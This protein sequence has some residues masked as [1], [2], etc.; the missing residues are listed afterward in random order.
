MAA[1]YKII[2]FHNA[3]IVS[4]ENHGELGN[5]IPGEH[6]RTVLCSPVVAITIPS[7]PSHVFLAGATHPVPLRVPLSDLSGHIVPLRFEHHSEQSQLA[8]LHPVL[9]QYLSAIIPEEPSGYARIEGNRRSVA[10]WE[11]FRLEPLAANEITQRLELLAE[12]LDHLFARGITVNTLLETIRAEAIFGT[13]ELLDAA[14][15]FLSTLNLEKIATLLQQDKALCETLARQMPEDPWA[16]EGIPLLMHWISKRDRH[17]KI[18]PASRYECP[19]NQTVLGVTG[20]HKDIASFA[21]ACVHAMRRKVTPTRG[22]AILACVRNEGIYLLEWIA[23]H[24]A[25]GIEWFFLY[26]NDNDDQSDD[27]LRTLSEQGIITWVNNPIKPGKAAQ[28]KAYGH[29]LSIV[30]D[31]LDFSWVQVLDGDEFLALDPERFSNLQ[32]YLLW[33]ETHPVDAISLNWRFV[34]SEPLPEGEETLF[35]DPLTMRNSRFVRHDVIGDPGSRLVKSMF[36]PAQV[37][38]SQAHYPV[39][40]YRYS[41]TMCL[42]DGTPHTWQSP[43]AGVPSSAAF[44]DHIIFEKIGI[45]HYFYK[46]PEEWMWKSSRNRGDNPSKQGLDLRNFV[47]GWTG[48][49]MSQISDDMRSGED[50]WMAPRRAPFL[51]ELENLKNLPG[52]MQVL[53]NIYTSYRE[54]SA[55][56][57]NRLQAENIRARH[58]ENNK[59][60]FDLINVP[61]QPNS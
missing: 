35:R 29:A 34:A 23:Y 47:D 58:S 21:H 22:P 25:I 54:R 4:E 41:T 27:I 30:P 11:L 49:F 14:L 8:F 40:S 32:D 51:S 9:D 17:G 38:Q 56:I 39:A 6:E 18:A 16:A 61:E 2:T 59:I 28:H 57:R 36:R 31:I 26:S 20:L 7:M 50:Q 10:G 1:F 5:L 13:P 37:I 43:P 46:S 45:Y 53:Q 24:R 42:S 19:Q 52:M 48:N 12:R 60:F 3:P 44:A 15:P 33:T 55:L